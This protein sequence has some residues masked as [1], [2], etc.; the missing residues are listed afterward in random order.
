[1]VGSCV[2]AVLD[3]SPH[4]ALANC[5]ESEQRSLGLASISAGFEEIVHS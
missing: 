1:M 5:N 2:M 4:V 3:E